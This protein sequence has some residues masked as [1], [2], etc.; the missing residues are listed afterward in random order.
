MR[1]GV[2]HPTHAWNEA[3]PIHGHGQPE[4][5]PPVPTRPCR[6]GAPHM[7]RKAW[8]AAQS[9]VDEGHRP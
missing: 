8:P 5:S 1:V 4:P 7:Q 3:V 9:D 6:R 2:L